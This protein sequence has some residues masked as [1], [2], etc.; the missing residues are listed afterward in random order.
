M[1]HPGS[2]RYWKNSLLV[3]FFLGGGCV[4]RHKI[5]HIWEI[6]DNTSD[7]S[8][9]NFQQPKSRTVPSDDSRLFWL[10]EQQTANRFTRLTFPRECHECRFRRGIDR[11]RVPVVAFLV[12]ELFVAFI[13][14]WWQLKDFL[15]SPRKLGKMNPFWRAY[16]SKG[17][18]PPTR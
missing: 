11:S 12:V 7:D 10:A 4:K 13:T 14:G 5:W 1:K 9:G 2:S 17:L 15:F 3:G 6:Q 18:K 16:F 8:M